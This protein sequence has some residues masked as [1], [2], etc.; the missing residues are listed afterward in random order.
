MRKE[1]IIHDP[2]RFDE[3]IELQHK[4]KLEQLLKSD[5][6]FTSPANYEPRH[7]WHPFP[8][9]FPPGLPRLFIEHLT[10]PNEKVLDPMAGSCT[11]LIE[12]SY[13]HREA[14]G[15]DIDPLSLTIG[16]AK[17]QRFSH[18]AASK[19]G[20]MVVENAKNKY[21]A[22]RKIL[23]DN[24][25]VRF[26]S[27]TLEFLDYWFLKDSQLEL[28]ALIHEIEKLESPGIRQFLI[29]VLSGIIITKSGGI[30]L[31]RDLAHTRPHRVS[32][33]T[34]NPAFSEFSKRLNKILQKFRELPASNVFLQMSNAKNMP[35]E[36]E[37]IDLIVT[38]PPYANNAIDYMR[39]HKF[40][41]VWFGYKITD[42]K[43][44]RK[45]YVGAEAYVNFRLET[46]PGYTNN[47]VMQMMQVNEKKGRALHR[48]YSDMSEIIK[49][50]YRVLKHGKACIIVVGSSVLSGF[51]VETHL[52]LAEIGKQHGFDLPHIGE[53]N[54]D[55]DKRM[56]PT[57][58]NKND[59]Q[60][61]T[62]MH[63]EYV[64]GFWKP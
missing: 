23:E 5:L 63:K 33:K 59:S 43:Y 30:T 41:L 32:S 47:K 36:N 29:L 42:L 34:P 20:N 15:F 22:N 17:F 62:R 18:E 57:S 21:H 35:L 1:K 12:S 46:L 14:I 58:R 11:T 8:A 13:L 54:I 45:T 64:I 39:A 31:A 16:N 50:M 24:L 7:T 55:R 26:D 48:Y 25:T 28:L 49:E 37:S 53:R 9:K 10:Q 60:I 56:L 2:D 19:V 27:E 61:E 44:I 38:S 6:D 40:S 52:C 4:K 3:V 51:D